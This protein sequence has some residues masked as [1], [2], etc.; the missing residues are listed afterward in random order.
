MDEWRKDRTATARS[1]RRGKREERVSVC[2]MKG[3]RSGICGIAGNEKVELGERVPYCTVLCCSV[4]YCT[5]VLLSGVGGRGGGEGE[6]WVFR[7]HMETKE[8]KSKID[9]DW[10]WNRGGIVRS[11]VE[12]GE[13][14]AMIGWRRVVEY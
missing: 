3:R 7:Q 11:K 13:G 10:G 5:T 2:V 8:G 1:R 9:A 12:T 14:W 6:E 4:Q